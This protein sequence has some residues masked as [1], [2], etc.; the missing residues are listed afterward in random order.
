MGSAAAV[1]QDGVCSSRHQQVQA[2]CVLLSSSCIPSAPGT[3]MQRWQ[4]CYGWRCSVC[5]V[6]HLAQDVTKAYKSFL[7]SWFT[8]AIFALGCITSRA[9]GSSA[10]RHALE[11]SW[12]CFP[13]HIARRLRH[14]STCGTP[15]SVCG[16]N[17]SS[18]CTYHCAVVPFQRMHRCADCVHEPAQCP[19]QETGACCT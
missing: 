6:V 11:H 5:H 2:G 10:C 3:G 17:S 19:T 16:G 12:V 8:H 18:C 13:P 9:D 7:H 15:A 4:V 1:L 14:S